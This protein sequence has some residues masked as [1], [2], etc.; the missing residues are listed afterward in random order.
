MLMS[1]SSL[2][3]LAAVND[4]MTLHWL[5]KWTDSPWNWDL[6]LHTCHLALE[7]PAVLVHRLKLQLVDKSSGS[8]LTVWIGCLCKGGGTC[9]ILEEPVCSEKVSTFSLF[10]FKAFDRPISGANCGASFWRVSQQFKDNWTV[11]NC[12]SVIFLWKSPHGVALCLCQCWTPAVPLGS[13][14]STGTCECL[15]PIWG[16]KDE[17]KKIYI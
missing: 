17:S 12:P 10:L 2:Y 9:G 6:T 16:F 3:I 14:F 7:S 8:V 15:S 11:Q 1:W 5:V 4:A 13:Y